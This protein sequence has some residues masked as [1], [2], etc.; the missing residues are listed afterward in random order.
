VRKE[1]F[2]MA[3][4]VRET[5]TEHRSGNNVGIYS[6]CSAHPLV[7]EA[8]IAQAA[9]D[10]VYTLIEATSNQV[11][12]DGG[13]TGMTPAD[14]RDFVYTIADRYQLPHDRIFLGGDHLG[15]NRWQK[16]PGDQA[17]A[18]A[19]VLVDTYVRAGYRK[20]HIDC[21]MSCAGD[22]VPPGDE[23]VAERAARLIAIAEKAAAEVGTSD[24]ILYVIGTEV[25]VPGGAHETLGKLTPTTADAAR[26]TLATHKAAL[27]AKGLT[28]VWPKIGALVVQPA[29][30]FDHVKVVDY[31]SEAT[32]NLRTV[33]DDEPGIVFEAHSTDYQ[34]PANMAAL[35]RDHWAILK[36]G[37]GLTFALREGFLALDAIEKWLIPAE[38]QAHLFDVIEKTMLDDPGYWQGYYDGTPDEQHLARVFSYSDR[39]RYYWPQP[40][41]EAAAAQLIDNL[42]NVEIPE[43]LLSQ[44]L[45][46][47]YRR[48]RLGQLSAAPQDLLIDKIRDA[49]R[50]YAAACSTLKPEPAWLA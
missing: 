28:D 9:A 15:P 7:L 34:T 36:V 41:I 49:I 40:A 14:F 26:T 1:G 24:E 3:N 2:I 10:G 43:P 16:L 17:M 11:D 33:L 19:D 44:F 12:Q 20:I 46:D 47:Q 27:Q 23:L 4:H 48:L 6:V 32:A 50:P 37:P 31:V 30:E 18:K 38:N 5:V 22:P 29:V 21:S 35:V 39:M 45:P 13:Y 25:P 8:A 42:S